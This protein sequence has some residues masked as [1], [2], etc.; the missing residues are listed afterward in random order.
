V[1]FAAQWAT[2]GP[3][4]L[5]TLLYIPLGVEVA[6]RS[7]IFQRLSPARAGALAAGAFATIPAAVFPAYWETGL[8]GQHR[9]V[10]VSYFVFLVL[11]FAAVTA[12]LS[13][14]KIPGSADWLAS[15]GPRWVTAALFILSL[16]TTH[17]GYTVAADLTYGRGAAFDRE[18][19]RRHEALDT[20][21]RDARE[22]C[23]IPRIVNKPESFFV[24]DV[25][26]DPSNWINSAYAGYF[27]VRAVVASH[28]ENAH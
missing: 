18:M 3:L 6:R 25:S 2:S 5:A 10:S 28:S 21:R 14:R 17:N 7:P 15:T 11:W 24:L 13:G 20:C 8:L 1:R 26:G 19:S 4:L 22:T 16:T 23:E 9:T 12:M 27:H